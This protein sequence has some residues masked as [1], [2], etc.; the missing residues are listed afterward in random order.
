M[1]GLRLDVKRRRVE[2]DG[3]I[4]IQRG[5]LE[6]VACTRIGKTHESLLVLDCR[7]RDLKASLLA[8]GLS[9]RPQV[10]NFGDPGE[11][12]GEKVA[13]TVLWE[14]PD[15]PREA[16]VED[17]ILDSVEG[18]PMERRGFVFTGSRFVRVGD[19]EMFMSDASG[20]IVTTYH[21]PDAI[22]DNPSTKGGDDTVYYANS[23]DVPRAG[24]P[25]RAVFE[26][27]AA[28]D[29]RAGAAAPTPTSTPETPAGPTPP[30]EPRGD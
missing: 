27:I 9:D 6:V 2:V 24:T 1:P 29:E 5:L 11:L 30:P 7:P 12:S 25:V 21:D 4:C 18:R 23:K 22:L 15:G 26:P 10:K 17:L 14:C 16:R 20:Q 28:G 19:R 8:L 13:I 3:R